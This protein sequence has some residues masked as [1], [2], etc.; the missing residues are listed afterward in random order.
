MGDGS[1]SEWIEHDGKGIPVDA[2]QPVF[3]KFASGWK[4]EHLGHSQASYWEW[5][6]ER[7]GTPWPSDIVAYR[8]VKP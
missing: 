1:L 2:D 6:W 5:E 8:V 3:V 4:D 7:V